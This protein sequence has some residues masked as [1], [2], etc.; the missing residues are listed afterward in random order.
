MDFLNN[1]EMR[2]RE[3]IVTIINIAKQSPLAEKKDIVSS[4]E[5]LRDRVPFS[6][7]GANNVE[8]D[9]R[10]MREKSRIWDTAT[11]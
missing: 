11:P 8:H 5:L 9:S 3:G 4:H 10:K 2:I 7:T 6:V 1:V